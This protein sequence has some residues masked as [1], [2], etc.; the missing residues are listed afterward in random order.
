MPAPIF[1][2]T[3]PDD[4]RVRAYD[5]SLAASSVR[6]KAEFATRELTVT[7]AI[8]QLAVASAADGRPHG[9]WFGVWREIQSDGADLTAAGYEAAW[10][11][12]DLDAWL[13]E[14]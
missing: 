7:K 13:A 12:F 3:S 5:W 8:A 10:E 6:Q 4:A 9:G 2:K 14:Q 1:A 11:P